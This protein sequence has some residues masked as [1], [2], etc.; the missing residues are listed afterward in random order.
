MK[1]IGINGNPGSG[2][3]TASNIIFKDEKTMIIHLDDIFDDIK[4]LLPK[5]N[6][7]TFKKDAESA[8]IINRNSLLYKTISLKYI[9]KQIQLAKKIY[10]NKMLKKY[11]NSAYDEGVEYFIIEGVHLENYD[12]TY[13][14]DYLIFINAN[15]N[16]RINRIVE[17]DGEFSNIIFN[18][19]L[20]AVDHINLDNYDYVIDNISSI[21]NFKD[22]CYDIEKEIR[23]KHVKIKRKNK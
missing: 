19:S 7:N 1:I 6:V 16:D 11:I 18:K 21:E 3:T 17:R 14:I 22:K 8:I 10:A 4:E 20:N 5:R 15:I 2:K 9:N 23:K 12:I 13:L